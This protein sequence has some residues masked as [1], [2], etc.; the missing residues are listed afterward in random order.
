MSEAARTTSPPYDEADWERRLVEARA[1]RAA[2]L[3]ARGTGE[4]PASASASAPVRTVRR[5]VVA[6]APTAP[7]DS[8]DGEAAPTAARWAVD[9]GRWRAAAIGAGAVALLAVGGAVGALAV[10]LGSSEDVLEVRPAAVA[11]VRFDPEPVPV[12]PIAAVASASA[13]DPA[14]GRVPLATALTVDGPTAPEASGGPRI[15]VA[16][17]APRGVGA[18]ARDAMAGGLRAEVARVGVPATVEHDI[19]ETHLRFYHA[20]DAAAAGSLARLLGV[21]SRDFTAYRPSPR[22]GRVEVWMAGLAEGSDKGT[23]GGLDAAPSRGPL[24]RA[25][26]FLSGE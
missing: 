9:P 17:Y 4:G 20:A 15:E 12:E 23:D 26:A 19:A 13:W 22:A 11:P 1:R 14:V 18:A 8:I 16:I 2:V 3:R 5:G 21:P 10:H 25:L 7:D 6:V 24:G